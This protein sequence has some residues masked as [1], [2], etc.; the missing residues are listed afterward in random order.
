ML[1]AAIDAEPGEVFLISPWLRDVGLPVAGLGHFVSVFG[2]YRDTVTLGDLLSVVASRHRL[3]VVTR[4]PGELVPLARLRTLHEVLR[5][6]AAM[7]AE[8]AI[9]DYD[10]VDRAVAALTAQTDVLTEEVLQHAPTLALGRSLRERGAD[11]RVLDRL[12]AKLLWTAAGGLL[13]SANFTAAGL[14]RNEELMVEVT[15]PVEHRQLG[16]VAKDFASRATPVDD[17]DLRPAL[18]RAR[19]HPPE[20]RAWAEGLRSEDRPGLEPLL[21][22]LLTY[23][24]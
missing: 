17:Y 21:R 10:A 1:L 5:S 3:T 14:A 7:I 12:H 15:A 6:R 4:T 24:R 9:R 19:V 2:G 8:E 13:G 22:E 20:L 18:R 16:D 11:F 23:L